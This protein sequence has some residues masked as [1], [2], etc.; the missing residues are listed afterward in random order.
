MKK[1]IWIAVAALCVVGTTAVAA[2][3]SGPGMQGGMGMQRGMGAMG[4]QPDERISLGVQG[5]RKQ[6]QLAMMRS[7]LEAVSDIVDALARGEF[8]SAAQTAQVKLGMTPQMKRMCN[9]FQNED[10]RN[11]ALAFHASA[12][13]LA[14]ALKTHDTSASLQALH[15]TMQYC[16]SCHSTYRQ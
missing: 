6:H 14:K 12:D 11:L 3:M 10:F 7:H 4:M 9:G 5:P 1:M 15:V 13:D 2:D 16:T 8:D